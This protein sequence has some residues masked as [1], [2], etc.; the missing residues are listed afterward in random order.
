MNQAPV[1]PG[2]RNPFTTADLS[3]AREHL[4]WMGGWLLDVGDRYYTVTDDE[5]IVR[6]LRGDA[7]V[8]R[9]EALKMWDETLL[10][11]HL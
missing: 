4:D 6:D 3:E 10:P 11:A 1:A 2:D 9:C 7:F 5:H 8:R